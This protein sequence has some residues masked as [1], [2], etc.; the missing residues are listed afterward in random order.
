MAIS[1]MKQPAKRGKGRPFVKGQSGNP[2]GRPK[3]YDDLKAMAREH[4]V[5]AIQRLAH[6]MRGNDPRASVAA[7]NVLLDRGWGKAAQPVEHSGEIQQSY[8][9]RMPL[10]E[11]DTRTWQ[12]EHAPLI[13]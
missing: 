6:W 4:T 12:Q 11:Q 7:A 9:V 3:E 10:R 1:A 5:E 2:K 13:Q 8:V